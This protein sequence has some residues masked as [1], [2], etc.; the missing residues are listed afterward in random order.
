MR[1]PARRA[2]DRGVRVPHGEGPQEG[3][4]RIPRDHRGAALGGLPALSAA[5]AVDGHRAGH[6]P[7]RPDEDGRGVPGRRGVEADDEGRRRP[8]VPVPHVLPGDALAGRGRVGVA[9]G[10][11]GG[12]PQQAARGD[13]AD[14]A[15]APLRGARG[16]VVAGR[17]RP[18]PRLPARRRAGPLV[19]VRVPV[20]RPRRRVGPGQ[21]GG[22]RDEDAGPRGR[23]AAARRLRRRRGDDPLPGPVLR[24]VSPAPGVLRLPGQVPLLRPRRAGLDRQ[25]GDRRAGRADVLP[26]PAAPDRGGDPAGALPAR[27]HPGGEPLRDR[28]RADPPEPP[29]DRVPGRARG[30]EAAGLRS[31]LDRQ[32]GQRR[33]LVPGRAGRVRAVLRDEARPPRRPAAG[34]LVCGAAAVAPRAGRRHG[35]RPGLLR[36]GLPPDEPAG[37]RGDGLRD[38]QQPRPADRG[39]RSAATTPTSA[40]RPT[41][42][43]AGSGC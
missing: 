13:R 39:C 20:Q 4:R 15:R 19:A 10:G 34:L 26:Q 16:M 14:P 11:P 22:R 28:R 35:G 12:R 40:W 27:L 24:R 17:V 42:P 1:G 41:R 6:G 32:G 38:G 2:A 7:Q 25:G 37:L 9:G 29:P 43:S 5:R 36:P 18:A 33:R 31:L 23:R 3:R 21:D 30:D 8:G